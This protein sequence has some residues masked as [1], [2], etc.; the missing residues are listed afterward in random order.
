MEPIHN[1]DKIPYMLNTIR[2]MCGVTCDEKQEIMLSIRRC[3]TVEQ[4]AKELKSLVIIK[5]L[6]EFSIS[7]EMS[8]KTLFGTLNGEDLKLINENID[9][10]FSD[11]NFLTIAI[12]N[13]ISIIKTLLRT[14]I[15]SQI[16]KLRKE[17]ISSVDSDR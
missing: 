16:E 11:Q 4:S 3:N 13:L 6:R 15:F 5:R 14:E 10:L 17:A 8:L 7:L 2:R 9:K 12:R 1:L